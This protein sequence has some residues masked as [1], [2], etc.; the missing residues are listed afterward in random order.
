MI[1]V[2]GTAFRFFPNPSH[3]FNI[4]GL[5]FMIASLPSSQQKKGLCVTP[6][7]CENTICE[8]SVIQSR[9]EIACFRYLLFAAWIYIWLGKG[10]WF[11]ALSTYQLRCQGTTFHSAHKVRELFSAFKATSL[12]PPARLRNESLDSAY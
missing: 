1:T 11:L 7:E 2:P 3:G 6:S 8:D 5:H 10:M 12:K 9:L 4:G